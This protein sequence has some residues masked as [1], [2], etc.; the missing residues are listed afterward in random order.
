MALLEYTRQESVTFW[1]AGSSI[2]TSHLM[3]NPAQPAKKF[4]GKHWQTIALGL[5]VQQM[6]K[7]YYFCV[8][9]CVCVR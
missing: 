4:Q 7:A 6:E 2:V 8:H 3:F 1:D 9:V 5:C